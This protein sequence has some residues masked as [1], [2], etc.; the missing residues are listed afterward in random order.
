PLEVLGRAQLELGRHEEAR[1]S[2]E[3]GLELVEDVEADERRGALRFGLAR[4]RWAGGERDAE[5][6]ELAR[7]AERELPS[8]GPESREARAAA[9]AWLAER[10]AEASR[11]ASR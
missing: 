7:Q 4:A 6:L 2:F 9:R 1:R 11:E 8:D 10:E 5:T 3:R